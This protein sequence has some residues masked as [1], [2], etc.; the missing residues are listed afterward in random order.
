[1]TDAE[2]AKT[3]RQRHPEQF[4]SVVKRWRDAHPEKIREYNRRQYEKRKARK[5]NES[6]I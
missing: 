5:E 3:W 4:Y 2:R 1:M 6:E